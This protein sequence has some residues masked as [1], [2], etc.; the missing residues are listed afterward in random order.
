MA[1]AKE[2]AN[3]YETYYVPE[4]SKFPIWASF[5][6]FLMVYG[7][8]RVLNDMKA[9]IDATTSR[10]HGRR[11]RTPIPSCSKIRKSR[12]HGRASPAC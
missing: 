3:G 7:L 1:K 5:G 10:R 2:T 4:Q 9:G 11:S 6:M 8:G 12:W